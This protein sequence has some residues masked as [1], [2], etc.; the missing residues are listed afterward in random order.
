MRVLFLTPHF[1]YPPRQGASLRNWGFIRHLASRHEVHLLSLVAP[2]QPVDDGAVGD[3]RRH[4]ASVTTFTVPARPPLKR[5]LQLITH[6]APDLTLRLWTPAFAAILADALGRQTFDIVQVEGLELAHYVEPFLRARRNA[7]AWVYDAHNAEAELQH[8][9]WR[10]D[11]GHPRR[12]WAAAYSFIQWQKLRRYERRWLPRFDALL[13]VSPEDR[14]ALRRT[15]GVEAVVVPNGVD[16]D[17]FAPGRFAPAPEMADHPSVV[18][19]GKMDFRPNV[20]GVLWF[21][22][23]VWPRVRRACP[24]AHFWVVGQRPARAVRALHGRDHIIVTGA[25]PAVEP[26]VA[27]ATVFVAPLRMGSGTR[28][29]LLQALSLERPAVST[30]LG[31][32]GLGAHDGVHLRVADTP[33]DFAGAV[34]ELLE[35]GSRA[36]CLGRAGRS[37]VRERFDWRVVLPRLEALYDRLDRRR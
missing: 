12:W 32:A 29:K 9:I 5:L 31:C 2:G 7:P 18:F 26:Y 4:L 21:A 37:M 24:E 17:Y 10:A 20:D 1:P 23:E 34:V 28:L 6:P 3:V 16:T 22:R 36:A 30:R 8:S 13:C 25:V 27:G 19:T 15:A 14:E 11:A 33:A 35:D